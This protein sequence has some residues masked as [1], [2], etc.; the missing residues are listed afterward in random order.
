M[1]PITDNEAASQAKY[2]I[3]LALLKSAAWQ[4]VVNDEL[5]TELQPGS[6]EFSVEWGR[7]IFAW[8]DDD[9]SQSWRVT[10]FE[11][12]EAEIRLRVSRGLAK[13]VALI[14][15]RDA[16]RWRAK[17][18]LRE[19]PVNERRA[20]YGET[21][22]QLIASRFA[23]V[24]IQ[25]VNTT[26]NR[27]RLMPVQYARLVIEWRHETVL[28]I[29]ANNGEAQSEIDGVLAA[30]LIWLAGYNERRE[31]GKQA[32]RLWLCVPKGRAQTT[33][34]RLTLV[35]VR[36]TGAAIECFEVDENESALTALRPVTQAE[37]INSHERELLW[38][39]A[40]ETRSRWRERIVSLAPDL[41]EARYDALRDTEIFSING[42]EFARVTHASTAQ[43]ASFGV[44]AFRP[45]QQAAPALRSVKKLTEANFSELAQLARSIATE[46]Q[47]RPADRQHPFHRLRA[48]AWL[49]SLLR[50]DIRV[51]DAT[52]D[53]RFV[54]SQIPAW[55]AD[56]RSVIDLL[57]VNDEGRLVVIEIKAAEDANL[58][59][60]GLDYW[61][62]V[63]Q[64]RVRGEFAR[65]G[66]FPGV[67]LAD[68]SPLLY[69][70]APRLRFH[71]TFKIIA[72]CLA[73]EIEAYQIGLNSNWRAGVKVHTR[74]R[75]NG[76]ENSAV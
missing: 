41:I 6:Y 64:A 36:H 38:P 66:L 56:E 58:P 8:W 10:N 40:A 18:K 24:R 76:S 61:L 55:R 72:C 12:A 47:A 71:R 45:Q 46:R 67:P 9:H 35:D 7:L 32:K 29:G 62:R 22:A 43:R 15:L 49:E 17:Q 4:M 39:Q 37:L 16:E 19:L 60:Q 69:L 44:A 28:V 31:A 75:I 65:R 30:G 42:L 21:L 13:E 2:D 33:L 25:R 73:P 70:V 57:A 54:Y 23:G 63:E 53:P 3:E 14:T 52:L 59:L 11:I 51:L 20:G 48:E 68:R 27:A 26:G 1:I 50:R 74:E 34:E 5:I